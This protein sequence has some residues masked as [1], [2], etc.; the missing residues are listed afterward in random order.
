[1]MDLQADNARLASAAEVES[2]VK[3]ARD[4]VCTVPMEPTVQVL[5]KRK[6]CLPGT[7]DK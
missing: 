2:M 1:M 5:G 7:G 4:A 6:C 3:H